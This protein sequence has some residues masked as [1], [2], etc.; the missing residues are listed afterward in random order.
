MSKSYIENPKLIERKSFEII[1]EEIRAINPGFVFKDR[2]HEHIVKRVI[3]TTADFEYLDMLKMTD[4]F[5][6]S[7]THILKKGCTIYTDTNMALSGMNKRN[8][9]R[10]GV[11]YKCLIAEEG[12][13]ETA[14]KKGITRSMAA[15][16]IA[17]MRKGYKVFVIGNAPTALYRI[18]EH[19]D[20]GERSVK[21]IVGIPVG[22]VG[23]LESKKKLDT[24]DI[25]HITSLSRKGGSNVAASII[26]AVTYEML[27]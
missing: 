22:F 1:D 8:L 12:T 26:N 13:A 6:D 27:K 17:L 5:I 10:H 14:H 25:P 21:C 19:Y 4:D 7:L 24:Y 20:A 23:A 18:M 9:D 3:H 11:S 2:F 16:D 15:V